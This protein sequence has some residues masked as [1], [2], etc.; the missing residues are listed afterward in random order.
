M[1]RRE[2]VSPQPNE[3]VT[4]DGQVA[5]IKDRAKKSYNRQVVFC[6]GGILAG[7]L[8]GWQTPALAD[9]MLNDEPATVQASIVG[10]AVTSEIILFGAALG[11]RAFTRRR[12]GQIVDVYNNANAEELRGAEAESVEVDVDTAPVPAE[13][14]KVRVPFR[15]Y[16]TP[17]APTVLGFQGGVIDAL[18]ADHRV[19]TGAIPIG[20]AATAVSIGALFADRWFD[21]DVV[22]ARIA[23]IRYSEGV[24]EQFRRRGNPQA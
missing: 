10:G 24:L 11:E 5:K 18:S 1:W 21:K 6:A 15:N 20:I 9:R 12:Y 19:P 2:R 13:K 3:P 7:G 4:A 23:Q 14:N 8:A 22:D 16:L 17:A